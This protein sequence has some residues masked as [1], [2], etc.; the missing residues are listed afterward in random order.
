MRRQNFARTYV[1]MNAATASK[2][3]GKA[4]VSTKVETKT[5]DRS[6]MQIIIEYEGDSG[7]V[8]DVLAAVTTAVEDVDQSA[9][10]VF[11]DVADAE[12]IG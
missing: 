11:A 5:V 2:L 8:D 12:E 4:F 1:S 6:R 9:G 3:L 7:M 10:N